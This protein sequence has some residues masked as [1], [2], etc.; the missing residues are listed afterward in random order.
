MSINATRELEADTPTTATTRPLYIGNLAG[1]PVD[2]DAP[3]SAAVA[4]ETELPDFTRQPRWP[5]VLLAALGIL[6]LAGLV[7]AVITMSHRPSEPVDV[8]PVP[9]PP[10]TS[11]SAVPPPP[12]AP[13]PAPAPAYSSVTATAATLAPPPPVL[14]PEPTEP[15]PGVRQRLHD[16]FP[17]LFPGS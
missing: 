9:V 16:M 13:T 8:D 12:A 10:S 11:T 15:K 6:V 2:D 7:A 14:Q 1:A 17:R 4:E 5:S 3:W